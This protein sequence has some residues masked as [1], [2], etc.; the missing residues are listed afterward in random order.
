MGKSSFL[1]AGLLPRRG[2]DDRH[3]LLM[4]FVRPQRNVLTGDRA[5]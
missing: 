1:R 4:G 2:R 3:F 5:H